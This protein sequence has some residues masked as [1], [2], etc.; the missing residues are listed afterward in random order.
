MKPAALTG[1]LLLMAATASAQLTLLP[2]VGFERAK[3]SI[4]YNDLGSFSPLGNCG[5]GSM[6]ASLRMDYRFKNGFG[7]F[8][9]IASSPALV[10]FSFANPTAALTNYKASAASLQ[11]RLEAGLQYSSKAFNFKKAST[12]KKAS[13]AKVQKT[14]APKTCGGYTYHHCGNQRTA[15]PPRQSS[16]LN[17]RLQPSLGLAY[18]PISKKD[19]LYNGATYQYNAG[20]WKTAVVSA[21]A[22]EFG[23]GRERIMTLSLFYTKAL[24]KLGE[25]TIVSEVNGKPQTSYFSSKSSAWGLALGV[26]FS[27]SKTKKT[28]VRKPEQK[29]KEYKS[30]CDYY[31]S[32]C[33]KRI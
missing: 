15:S 28:V 12:H 16:N 4:N 31:R 27:L 32:R 1:M 22:F 24:G 13:E 19:M 33:P 7:P 8:A 14:E 2:Q 20:N 25:Q 21:M 11:W 18:L 30:R 5:K 3:T 9:G 6:K 29:E 23:R 17:L 26:P 10:K